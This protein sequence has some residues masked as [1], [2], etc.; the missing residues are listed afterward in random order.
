MSSKRLTKEGSEILDSKPMEVPVG[1]MRPPSL[2]DQVRRLIRTEMSEQEYRKGG[3]TFEESEE[4]GEEEEDFGT[5]Y[6]LEYHAGTRKEVTR[7]EMAHIREGEK[8]FD[9]NWELQKKAIAKEKAEIA[10][11]RK[12]RRKD[13]AVRSKK[14]GR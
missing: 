2:Q 3:E 13:Y 1:F 10:A 6:E 7:A 12:K 9:K 5:P 11:Y 8:E 4:F 14:G